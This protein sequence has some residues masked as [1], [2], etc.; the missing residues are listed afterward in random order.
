ML[1]N[2][3][4]I[5]MDVHGDF[6]WRGCKRANQTIKAVRQYCNGKKACFYSVLLLLSGGCGCGCYRSYV[7]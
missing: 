4:G 7:V 1:L 5:S 6:R 3:E 2:N